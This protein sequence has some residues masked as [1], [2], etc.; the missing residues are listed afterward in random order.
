MPL[1]L[2][3]KELLCVLNKQTRIELPI[4]AALGGPFEKI[5][6]NSRLMPSSGGN[7]RIFC[8]VCAEK[9]LWLQYHGQE[10]RHDESYGV[11]EHQYI[12][13]ILITKG[14]LPGGVTEK[15]H[16][17][18][19]TAS[20]PWYNPRQK[21]GSLKRINKKCIPIRLVYSSNIINSAVLRL[22]ETIK[23]AVNILT[24]MS[25]CVLGPQ[26]SLGWQSLRSSIR[27]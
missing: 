20:P 9:T 22:A 23:Y 18:L 13:W 6:I 21:W 7:E 24:W 16:I 1:R 14:F 10:K 19:D 11:Y 15:P 12:L 26:G 2:L 25:S 8:S 4:I 27:K 3:P 17:R 5:C